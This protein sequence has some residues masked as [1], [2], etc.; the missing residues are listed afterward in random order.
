[1]RS[2]NVKSNPEF[3]RP[4]NVMDIMDQV[5]KSDHPI[6]VSGIDLYKL[7]F[8]KLPASFYNKGIRAAQVETFDAMV[9]YN[10]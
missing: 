2:V 6:I 3:Y 5:I 10:R 7:G 4:K 1:M 9:F 8:Y